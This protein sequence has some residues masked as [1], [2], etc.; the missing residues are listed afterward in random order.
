LGFYCT[1]SVELAKEW[2]CTETNSGYANAYDF[3]AE[4]LSI[5]NLQNG[6]YNILNWLA[7]LLENRVFHTSAGIAEEGRESAVHGAEDAG[8]AEGRHAH[9]PLLGGRA[10]VFALQALGEI[11]VAQ[12][13]RGRVLGVGRG[14]GLGGEDASHEGQREEKCG[15]KMLHGVVSG[16]RAPPPEGWEKEKTAERRWERIFPPWD[17]SSFPARSAP[18]G[19]AG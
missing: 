15:K 13:G 8:A 17:R 18:E 19:D 1:E 14:A 10:P 12:L 3:D 4:G 5:L 9:Q 16:V 6:E 11:L 2:A 7:I